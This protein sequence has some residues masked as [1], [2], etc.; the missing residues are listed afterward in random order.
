MVPPDCHGR[1]LLLFVVFGLFE[2]PSGPRSGILGGRDRLHDRRNRSSRRG[3]RDLAVK[4]EERQG[5]QAL[6]YGHT[7]G[8]FLAIADG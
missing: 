8:T 1:E 4:N 6:L 3:N 2:R 5:Q 7:A